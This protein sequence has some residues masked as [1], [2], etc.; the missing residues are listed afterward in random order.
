[1][2]IEMRGAALSECRLTGLE[3]SAIDR[4]LMVGGDKPLSILGQLLSVGDEPTQVVIHLRE[5]V[6]E[7]GFTLASMQSRGVDD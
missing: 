1:M 7:L 3:C 2:G 6:G 4:K 5:M